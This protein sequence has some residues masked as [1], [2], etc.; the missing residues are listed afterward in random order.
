MLSRAEK[1]ERWPTAQI[2]HFLEDNFKIG[3]SRG[4]VSVLTAALMHLS[5]DLTVRDC[6]LEF[7]GASL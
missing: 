2:P 6:M 5:L 7:D 1:L 4:S 3:V